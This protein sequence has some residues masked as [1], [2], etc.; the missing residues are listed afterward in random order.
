[1]GCRNIMG[2]SRRAIED[3]RKGKSKMG[4]GLRFSY[5]LT[6]A[7]IS[8]PKIYYLCLVVVMYIF[9]LLFGR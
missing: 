1:M 6:N 7:F 8:E 9:S 5:C 3:P 4:S 2:H